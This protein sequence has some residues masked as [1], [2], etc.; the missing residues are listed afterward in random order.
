MKI[1]PNVLTEMRNVTNL[2][3]AK[4]ILKKY[5]SHV[6]AGVHVVGGIFCDII[7]VISE[8]EADVT[9]LKAAANSKKT[10]ELTVG[11][12]NDISITVPLHETNINPN[13]E[14]EVKAT[15]TR[16]IN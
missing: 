13:V 12:P 6:P 14:P 9:S 2:F 16:T 7:E 10:F 15:I 11:V 5:G 3:D 8:R 4:N 1:R